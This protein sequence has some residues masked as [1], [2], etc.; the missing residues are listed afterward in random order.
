MGAE[1]ARLTDGVDHF[2]ENLA[3]GYLIRGALAVNLRIGPFES[4]DFRGEYALKFFV[5]L[6]GIFERSRYR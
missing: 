2:A 5:N 4:L 6:A 3:V 1:R